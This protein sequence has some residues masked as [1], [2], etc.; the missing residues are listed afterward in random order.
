MLKRYLAAVACALMVYCLGATLPAEIATSAMA[1]E[2]SPDCEPTILPDGQIVFPCEDNGGPGGGGDDGGGG[3]G[4]GSGAVCHFEGREIECSSEFGSWDGTCYVR[5]AIPQPPKDSS[6]WGGND[7]GVIVECTPYP[8]AANGDRCHET[9]LEWAAD[10]PAGAQVSAE[11]L[12][13]RAV[14]QM[15]LDMGAIGS[16]PPSTSSDPDA[17]GQVGLPIW[18]WV[19]DRRDN[20]V[21][22]IERTASDGGLSVTARGELDRTVWTISRGGQDLATVTCRGADAAGT[23]YDGRDSTLPSPT[24]GFPADFNA[25]LGDLTLTGVAHWVVT[26]SSPNQN[27]TVSVPPQELQTQIRIGETQAILD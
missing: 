5:V 17:L 1:S 22:P 23:P 20:T 9:T 14:A 21:G 25:H 19:A 16:T 13:R 4:G 2:Q 24:C 6:Y 12:A 3:G 15:D 7:D 8:C 10:P 27:G 26:W 18:L 11:E